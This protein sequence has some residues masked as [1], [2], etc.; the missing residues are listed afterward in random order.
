MRVGIIGAGMMGL[1][2]AQRLTARGLRVTLYDREGQAGGLSTYHDYGGFTWDRFYHVILPTDS[3]LIGFLKE[4]GL[5]EGLRWGTMRTGLYANHRVYPVSTAFDLLRFPLVGL[6]GKLRL[7]RAILA[8]KRVRDWRCLETVSVEDWLVEMCGRR[9]Y[10]LFWK[11]LLLAK[12]GEHYKRVSAVF[13]WSYVTRLFSVREGGT[14]RN[15]LGYVTGGYRTVIARLEELIRAGGG[16]IRLGTSV[17][18]VRAGADGRII[19]EGEQGHDQFDKVVWT[20]PVDAGSTLVRHGLVEVTSATRPVEYLGV[21]CP[22]LVTRRPVLP[23]YTL[24]I[25]DRAVPFTGVIGM[26]SI[27]HPAETDGRYLTYFPQYVLSDDLYLRQPDER[28]K[29]QLFLGLRQLFPGLS[30]SDIVSLH[31]NRAAKVQP[32][33]VLEYSRVAP[34]ISTAHRNVFIL[35]SSQLVNCTLNNNEI[36]G[37]VDAFVS[38]HASRFV[39]ADSSRGRELTAVLSH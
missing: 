2:L 33:Q 19:V 1:A 6:W 36:I 37:A 14:Q 11:P 23:Y 27:V 26:S 5:G 16:D 7:A 38:E 35:N 12:L 20:G 10:E 8:C 15:Q 25:A 3:H 21:V 31:I 17:R 32:L 24:N 9:T 29:E 4:I 30:T 18:S 34:R 39:S 13:I 28:V 22:V